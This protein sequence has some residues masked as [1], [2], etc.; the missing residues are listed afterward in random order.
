VDENRKAYRMIAGHTAARNDTEYLRWVA[1]RLLITGIEKRRIAGAEAHG[2]C[3]DFEVGHD[4]TSF[5]REIGHSVVTIRFQ[6][7]WGKLEVLAS[8]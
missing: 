6:S 3:P 1:E 4:A 7:L 2:D 8:R 5:D